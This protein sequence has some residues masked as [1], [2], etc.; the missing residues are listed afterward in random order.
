M[1]TCIVSVYVSELSL[2]QITS[3]SCMCVSD[4]RVLHEL[5]EEANPKQRVADRV[6]DVGL[7]ARCFNII[8]DAYL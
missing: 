7:V 1:T 8:G 4:W 5:S 3:S 2:N 6:H